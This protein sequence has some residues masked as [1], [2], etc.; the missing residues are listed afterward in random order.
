MGILNGS[1]GAFPDGAIQSSNPGAWLIQPLSGRE[2]RREVARRQQK[3]TKK[4]AA[5]KRGF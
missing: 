3:R 4:A 5:P 1:V 2:L